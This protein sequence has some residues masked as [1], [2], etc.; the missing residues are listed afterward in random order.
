MVVNSSY[1]IV[2]IYLTFESK[3]DIL[4]ECST[5]M[6]CSWR[7]ILFCN[8]DYLL[9]NHMLKFDVKDYYIIVVV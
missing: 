1:S 7:K 6:L 9:T 3:I 2:V 8:Y 5:I 4:P